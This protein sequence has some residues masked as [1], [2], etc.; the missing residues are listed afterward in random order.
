MDIVVKT[1]CPQLMALGP[2]WLG[3]VQH[4]LSI[5][6]LTSEAMV[7]ISQEQGVGAI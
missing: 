7:P 2:H 6:T 4:G 1:D 5:S 3:R